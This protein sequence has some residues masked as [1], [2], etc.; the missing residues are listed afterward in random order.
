MQKEK[1]KRKKKTFLDKAEELGLI[2]RMKYGT[3][4]QD[5]NDNRFGIRF[6]YSCEKLA[7]LFDE[8]YRID[9]NSYNNFMPNACHQ[10]VELTFTRNWERS[11]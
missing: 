1:K 6:N 8:G 2:N 11:I 5:E 3:I 7:Q 10:E 9:V 4:I